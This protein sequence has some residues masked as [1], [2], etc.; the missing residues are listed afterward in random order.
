MHATRIAKI[1][2]ILAITADVEDDAA[3][4]KAELLLDKEMVRHR[5][6]LANSAKIQF[7]FKAKAEVKIP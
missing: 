7:D 3:N 2:R 6:W 1:E 5:L 4:E